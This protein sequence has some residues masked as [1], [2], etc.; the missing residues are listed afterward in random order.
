MI[1]RRLLWLAEGLFPVSGGQETVNLL[2]NTSRSAFTDE[3][4]YSIDNEN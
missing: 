4:K 1:S 2:Q 3:V